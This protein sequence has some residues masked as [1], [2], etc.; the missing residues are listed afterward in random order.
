MSFG[1]RY[2]LL[3]PYKYSPVPSFPSLGR[4]FFVVTMTSSGK[5]GFQNKYYVPFSHTK[6]V[7]SRQNKFK[8]FGIYKKRISTGTLSRAHRVVFYQRYT[9]VEVYHWITDS[10]NK[11]KQTVLKFPY[12]FLKTSTICQTWHSILDMN[13]VLRHL[14]ANVDEKSISF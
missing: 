4:S 5:G 12:G 11:P 9:L 10:C 8:G 7:K 6:S 13:Y 3:L 1:S 2:N 14:F